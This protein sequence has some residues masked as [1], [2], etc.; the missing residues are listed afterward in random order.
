MRSTSSKADEVIPEAGHNTLM[1][2]AL[3][4]MVTILSCKGD[5]FHGFRGAD[6]VAAGLRIRLQSQVAALLYSTA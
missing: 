5:S 3:Q 2:D 4:V 6:R 1:A